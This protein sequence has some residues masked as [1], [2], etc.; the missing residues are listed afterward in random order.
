MRRAAL[1]AVVLSACATTLAPPRFN[2]Q[3]KIFRAR[4]KA[5]AAAELAASSARLAELVAA[6]VEAARAAVAWEYEES[7]DPMTSAATRIASI[8]SVNEISLASPYDGRQRA[9]LIVRVRPHDAAVMFS[10]VRGQLLCPSYDGCSVEVRFDDDEA[11]RFHA[12]GPA[13]HL[14]TVLF[15]ERDEEFLARLRTASVVRMRATIY[16]GGSP[17]F[18]FHTAGLDASKIAQ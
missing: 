8:H 1:L 5:A 11:K 3:G 12:S 14:S 18:E 6:E 2:E 13:D 15:I 17:V 9:M 4:Q 16:E 7:I 10:I